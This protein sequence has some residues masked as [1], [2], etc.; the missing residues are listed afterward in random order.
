M[1]RWT[2][3]ACALLAVTRLERE[4]LP[5]GVKSGVSLNFYRATVSQA[6]LPECLRK[7]LDVAASK[8]TAAG[9]AA[10]SR[11]DPAAGACAASKGHLVQAAAEPRARPRVRQPRPSWRAAITSGATT[12][13]RTASGHTCTTSRKT[14]P[15]AP[16]AR[17]HRPYR[18]GPGDHGAEDDAGA[19]RMS[20]RV[21][22]RQ[23][24]TARRST[25][26]SGS[27]PR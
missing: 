3:L 23:R 2:V 25:R 11:P 14:E 7:Q 5:A 6:K 16:E 13:A 18:E 15:S 17:G 10:R 21:A 26:A 12:T 22:V 20:R 1:K 8:T 27:P 24:S 4:A 9:H 19:R